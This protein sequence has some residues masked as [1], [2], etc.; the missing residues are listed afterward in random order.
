[1]VAM[2][3]LSAEEMQ[4]CDRV[5]TERYGVASIA[6]NSTMCSFFSCGYSL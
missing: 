4:A 6:P 5:T 3:V 1:M 2:K